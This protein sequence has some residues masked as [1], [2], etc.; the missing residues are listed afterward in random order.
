MRLLT[1][2]VCLYTYEFWLSLWKIV[3]SSVILLLPLFRIVGRVTVFV[4]PVETAQFNALPGFSGVRAAQS[5]IVCGEVFC[6]WLS[7]LFLLAIGLIVCR[8]I[9][10]FWLTLWYVQTFLYIFIL[11]PQCQKRK[12]ISEKIS[13]NI[14]IKQGTYKVKIIIELKKLNNLI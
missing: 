1:D 8:S 10:G 14:P 9:S 6:K 3:R 7:V 13:Y 11:Y 4:P 12:V 5:S 2:F